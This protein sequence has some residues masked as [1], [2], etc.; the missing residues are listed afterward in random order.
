MTE[1]L[2][3]EGSG[4]RHI[5]DLHITVNPGEQFDAP[6]DIAASLLAQGTFKRAAKPKAKEA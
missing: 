2:T 4:P 1:K 3:Y 6:A 5:P